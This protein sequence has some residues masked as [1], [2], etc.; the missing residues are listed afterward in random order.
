MLALIGIGWVNTAGLRGQLIAHIDLAN[1]HARLLGFGEPTPWRPDY[2][3]LLRERHGI[4]FHV[5]AGCV[6]SRP[7][8]AYVEGYNQVSMSAA[9]R[10]WG[11]DVFGECLTY[12]QSTPPGRAVQ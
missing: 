1:G 9:K 7:L 12:A 10:K 6:V 11:R 8:I 2:A 5:V 4:E 3:R